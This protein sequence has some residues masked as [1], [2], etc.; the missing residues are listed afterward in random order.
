[1]KAFLVLLALSLEVFFAMG[2]N[3]FCFPVCG[4]CSGLAFDSCTGGSCQTSMAF[5][6]PGGSGTTFSCVKTSYTY[7]STG[8][9]W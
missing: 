3:I 9:K 6:K 8:A 4:G 5:Q 7:Y 1:M 2:G